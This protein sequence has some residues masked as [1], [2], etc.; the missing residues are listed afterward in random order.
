[1]ALRS[2]LDTVAIATCGAYTETYVSATGG[3][4]MASLFVSWG[5]LEEAPAPSA[6]MAYIK[7]KWL[8]IFWGKIRR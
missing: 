6:P 3:E 7:R 4:N 8:T 2:G 5:F 1:M